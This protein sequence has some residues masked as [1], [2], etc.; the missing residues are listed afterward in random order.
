ML[1]AHEGYI[2]TVR[3]LLSCGADIN[4]EDCDGDT[5]V[6]VALMR[7]KM[8]ATLA[9]RLIGVETRPDIASVSLTVVLISYIKS[10][11]FR[12]ILISGIDGVRI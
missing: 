4:A 1:A 2:S 12:T 7:H 3:I 6:H 10:E 5:S 11:T 9:E 8:A